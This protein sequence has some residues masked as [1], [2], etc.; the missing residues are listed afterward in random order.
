MLRVDGQREFSILRDVMSSLKLII[1]FLIVTV[2][3]TSA[4]KTV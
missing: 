2:K 3:R 4:I 1:L